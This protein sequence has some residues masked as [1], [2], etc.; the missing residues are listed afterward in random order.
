MVRGGS[1]YIMSNRHRTVYYI[2]VTTD[3]CRRV[4]QHRSGEGST[5]TKRYQC[6]DLI[7]H[8]TF[9][10]IEEAIARLERGVDQNT[11]SHPARPNG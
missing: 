4:M 1:V 11:E 8:E 10:R 3:L 2:G 6:T 7:Y 9:S 5:F